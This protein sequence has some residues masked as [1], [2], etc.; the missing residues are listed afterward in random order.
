VSALEA[1][2]RKHGGGPNPLPGEPVDLIWGI[3]IVEGQPSER[4]NWRFHWRWKP[5]YPQPKDTPNAG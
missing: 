2:W 5:S 1:G 4:V 3:G